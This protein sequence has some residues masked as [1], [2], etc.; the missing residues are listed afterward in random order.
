[1]KFGGGFYIARVAW[2][3]LQPGHCCAVTVLALII[4]FQIQDTLTSLG[5]M[6]MVDCFLQVVIRNHSIFE[7]LGVVEDFY[8]V[9][10]TYV[11]GTARPTLYTVFLDKK[12][13]KL[14]SF[15]TWNF[16]HRSKSQRKSYQKNSLMASLSPVGS[17]ISYDFLRLYNTLSFSKLELIQLT[18]RL[19][20]L[21]MT[22]AG[23]VGCRGRM[24]TN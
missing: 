15:K 2:Q 7:S 14:G 13:G 10:Q 1:M 12:L 5:V 3:I 24:K 18:Y 6:C 17:L 9:S 21:Y 20:G 4:Q 11:V 8:M 22:F 23:K 16:K 19:C